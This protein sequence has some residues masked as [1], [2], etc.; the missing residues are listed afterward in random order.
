MKRWLFLVILFIFA[1]DQGT[2]LGVLT[3]FYEGERVA[4]GPFFAL[5]LVYN[6]GISFGMKPFGGLW[7]GLALTGLTVSVVV[8]LLVWMFRE[9]DQWMRWGLACVIGGAVGNILDR[10][11]LGA[12]V[13][14]LLVHYQ[15]YEWPVFNVAD[16]F[17]CL[18][19][20]ILM[21]GQV[22]MKKNQECK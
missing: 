16:S 13:D 20:I 11:R 17:I 21:I 15:K 4:Y 3:H 7:G 8:A 6:S 19:V 2:K 10:F 14:F 1:F 22:R 5:T 12:V 9:K 18:G